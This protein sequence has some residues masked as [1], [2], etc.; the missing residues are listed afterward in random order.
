MRRI[1]RSIFLWLW[2]LVK[3]GFLSIV[4]LL[5]LVSVAINLPPVQRFAANKAAAWFSDTTG[6]KL[7]IDGFELRIPYFIALSGIELDTPDDEPLAKLQK[8]ELQLAWRGLLQQKV[9]VERLQVDGLTAHV[10]SDPNGRWN[11]DFILEAFAANEET[12][13]PADTNSSGG[14]DVALHKLLLSDIDLGYYNAESRDSFALAFSSLQ[15]RM[16]HM[17]LLDQIYEVDEI[18]W[19]DGH[20][21]AQ[22][23]PTAVADTAA[24]ARTVER[25]QAESSMPTLFVRTLKLSKQQFTYLDLGDGS[26]YSGSLAS[27]D[28]AMETLDLEAM[29]F[30]IASLVVDALAL[31]ILLPE[32]AEEEVETPFDGEIFAPLNLQAKNIDIANSDIV[33]SSFDLLGEIN[34][35]SNI[36]ALNLK[37]S[38][39]SSDSSSYALQ[40]DH[41]ELRYGALPKITRLSAGLSINRERAAL[42][43]LRLEM[44]SSRVSGGLALSYP[45]LGSMVNDLAFN[46]AQ[47]SL[48]PVQLHPND[49]EAIMRFIQP[50]SALPPLPAHPVLVALQVSGNQQNLDF[51]KVEF[52]TGRSSIKLIGKSKGPSLTEH[53]FDLSSLKAAVYMDDVHT[54]LPD[55]LDMELLPAYVSF[56]GK[57]KAGPQLSQLQ[58]TLMAL[59]YGEIELS[60]TTGGWESK[61]YDLQAHAMSTYLDLH[62]VLGGDTVYTCFELDVDLQHLS[63]DSMTGTAHLDI[64]E[65]RSDAIVLNNVIVS[66]SIDGLNHLLHAS[67]RDSA[68]IFN[69]RATAFLGDDMR[70]ELF[71]NLDGVDLEYMGLTEKDFRIQSTISAQY[72]EADSVQSGTLHIGPTLVIREGERNDVNTLT[73]GFFLGA[74]STGLEVQSDLIELYTASNMG[75]DDIIAHSKAIFKQDAPELEEQDGYWN[76]DFK[77]GDAELLSDLFLPSL[78]RFDPARVKLRYRSSDRHLDAQLNLPYI[79]YGGMVLDSVALGLRGDMGSTIGSF[80]FRQFAYDTLEID[81]LRLLLSPDSIGTRLALYIGDPGEEAPYRLGVNLHYERSLEPGEWQLRPDQGIYLNAKSWDVD[82]DALMRFRD[83]GMAIE[84]LNLQRKQQRLRFNKEVGE[85]TLHISAQ[86]FDLGSLAGIFS[87]DEALFGGILNAGLDLNSDGTFTGDGIIENLEFGGTDLGQFDFAG[88]ALKPDVYSL[89]ANMN[90][91]IVDFIV[92]GKIDASTEGSPVLDLDASLEKLDAAGLATLVPSLIERATGNIRGNMKVTGASDAP[93]LNGAFN[94]NNIEMRLKGSAGSY[95]LKKEKIRIEPGAFVFPSFSV[96]DSAGNKLVIDGKVLHTNFDNLQYD[97][98]IRSDRFTLIDIRPGANELFHGRL[99]VGTDIRIEGSQALPKVRSN[100]ALKRGSEMVFLVPES[101]YQEFGTDGLL[102]WVQFDYEPGTDIMTKTKSGSESAQISFGS[103]IDLSGTLDIDKETRM[104]IIIDPLAGDFLEIAGGGK[105][106]LGYDRAGRINLSGTYTVS[107]GTYQM[108]FYNIVKRVFKLEPGSRITWN[109]DPMNADL[110]LTALYPT[111]ASALG[112]MSSANSGAASE[113]LRRM[114]DWEVVMNIE[115]ELESPEIGF[116]L[117][118]SQN[119]RGSMAGAI[120]SRL[121]QLRENESE[122]NK[123]VFAL[124]VFN[125][126]ISEGGSGTGGSDAMANQARNSASQMLSQQLNNLS[127]QLVK[128]VELNFDLQSYGSEGATETD[129]SVDLSKTLFDDRVVVRVGST[130]ALE[131]NNPMAD[132]SQ[133]LMTNFIVEYKITED[134]RYRLKAFRK[135]DVEDILVGRIT[136]TGVGVLF[137]RAFDRGNE[138]FARDPDKERNTEDD[139]TDRAPEN[140]PDADPEADVEPDELPSDETLPK[141]EPIN[142]PVENDDE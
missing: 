83:E 137:R 106:A 44:G 100:I 97:L 91:G 101:S 72:A 130:V 5:V 23:G 138:V 66:D 69:M 37:A 71:A 136:R 129:L 40:L 57:G 48:E 58:G 33:V 96:A 30:G 36:Q 133:Q 29:D 82:S 74:D 76:L 112:L 45:G 141:E 19:R 68:A 12:P 89:S 11:Y 84:S 35:L 78:E 1:I 108:T 118:L 15:V 28:L 88:N 55:S 64:P 21:H 117:R 119:S 86:R 26:R 25:T 116:D 59:G 102:E 14:W 104:R 31:E 80:G 73:M 9:L 46:S 47:L 95:A 4:V 20:L 93:L 75:I 134:G 135:T 126:F 54:Y 6:G 92:K 124:M 123:Q 61:R 107:E 16:D 7:R 60:A 49:M 109:G 38:K 42:N 122:L 39:L 50:D 65:F 8:L 114:L 10:H 51:R 77:S 13:S 115:G 142:S 17:S 81:H 140:E 18:N 24:E 131:Q 110:R 3:W 127:D 98:R 53:R 52:S 105:L 120:D 139:E 79:K 2:L 111:R 34:T 87:K 125:T 113:G 85:E 94:F 103:A 43:N 41:A 32:S 70:A 132:Q 62:K 99:V 128:G 90:G 121:M 56:A 67:V 22:L 27:L 63:A